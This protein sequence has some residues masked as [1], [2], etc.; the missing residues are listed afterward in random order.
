MAT[1]TQIKN[2]LSRKFRGATL[3]D[4]QGISNWTVFEEAGHNLLSEIDP[5]ETIRHG[6]IDLFQEIYDYG[7]STTAPDLK[8]KKV[9]DLRPQGE[10]SSYDDFRQT[11][12]EDF[13]RE[14]KIIDN[15]FSV[16]FD[17]ATKFLRVAKSVSNSV[18]VT[19]VESSNYTAGTGVSNI[20]EDTILELEDDKSI[21]FDVSSGTNLITWAG[22]AVDIS[23]HTNKSSFFMEVYFPD[24]SIISSVK[25]RIGSSAT[26][27]YEITGS[28]HFGS[29][30][31]GVNLYRFD[32][33]GVSDAGT[34]DEDNIDYARLEI[35]TTSADTDI[36]IG[37]LSSKLPEPFELVYYSNALFRPTSGSTW[38]TLPTADTDILNL[39]GEA[40]NIF[41]YECCEIIASDLQLDVEKQK[42]HDELHGTPQRQGLYDQYK[43][44]KPNEPI[45]PTTRY[46][47]P[48][49]RN[50]R[51]RYWNPPQRQ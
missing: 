23:D 5:Y 4:V 42:Y 41:I 25:L 16:E 8:G 48:P 17:E 18:T 6:E 1:I 30:R 34:T 9:I 22:T 32:W 47:D 44:N 31:N 11:Y 39:E 36:R 10:R 7:L 21:R 28:I 51:R 37:K 45:R 2:I 14:K 29:I 35:T 20:T 13:D 46:Y 43:H 26:D 27:Y 3:D 33:N 38:L 19:D 49:V 50:F 40:Q 15:W 24:S 12:I